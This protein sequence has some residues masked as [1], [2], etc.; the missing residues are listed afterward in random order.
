MLV[1]FTAILLAVMPWTEYFWHFDG[2]LRGGQDLEFGL[3]SLATVFCLVLI[4]VKQ[5]KQRVDS[6][7]AVLR[8]LVFVFLDLS[9][10]APQ[11]VCR[12]TATSK[13]VRVRGPAL[14]MYNLPIRI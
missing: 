10:A 9:K 2:F 12:W 14:E 3:L 5:G 6:L 7:L 11:N 8:K 1:L 13:T 4:L